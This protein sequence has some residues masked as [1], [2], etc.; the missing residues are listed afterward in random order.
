MNKKRHAP[1]TLSTDGES[2]SIDTSE[3]KTYFKKTKN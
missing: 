1:E 2:V 3:A